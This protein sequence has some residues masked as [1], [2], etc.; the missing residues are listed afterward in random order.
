MKHT[1]SHRRTRVE[2]NHSRSKIKKKCTR[3]TMHAVNTLFIT[4]QRAR[5]S[6]KLSIT[7]RHTQLGGNTCSL[8]SERLICLAGIYKNMSAFHS[9]RCFSK[10]RRHNCKSNVRV[11][12]FYLLCIV[13]N[14]MFF[15]Y[16]QTKQ[17]IWTRDGGP[18]KGDL[19]VLLLLGL[20][21]DY[22][23]HG[24]IFAATIVVAGHLL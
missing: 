22:M 1:N 16:V 8:L 9:R 18:R 13:V 10:W 3:T 24:S 19:C 5:L 20:F 11:C 7:H 14:R 23:T 6:T 21:R 12:W 17:V 15:S 4:C 2:G